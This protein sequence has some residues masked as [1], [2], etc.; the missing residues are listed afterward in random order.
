MTVEDLHRLNVKVQK[1]AVQLSELMPTGGFTEATSMI[2]RSSQLLH[3]YLEKL[4]HAK[5]D[6]QLGEAIERIEDNLDEIT[7]VLDQLEISNKNQPIN[8]IDEFLKE[9]YNMLSLYSTCVN[10]VMNEKIPNEE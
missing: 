9:G 10:Q 2:I 6:H 8:F 3:S 1:G 5:T 4:I 7:F